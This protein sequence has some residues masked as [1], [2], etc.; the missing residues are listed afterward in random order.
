MNLGEAY[1]RQDLVNYIY[2][3]NLCL[4]LNCTKQDLHLRLSYEK[5]YFPD[6]ISVD[7]TPSLYILLTVTIGMIIIYCILNLGNVW[8]MWGYEKRLLRLKRQLTEPPTYDML[9]GSTV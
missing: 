6:Y 4:Q 7:V 2:I 5:Y 1:Y 8:T 9:Y 3:E